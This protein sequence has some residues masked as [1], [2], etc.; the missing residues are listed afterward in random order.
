MTMPMIPAP[1]NWPRLS[2]ALVYRDASAAIDW[3]CRAFGFAVRLKIEG[4]DGRILHSELTYGEAVMM[5]AQ[6]RGDAS[7]DSWKAMLKSPQSL[8]GGNSQSIMLYV[9]DADAHCEQARASG[10]TIVDA[11]S[12][13]DYGAEYWADRSYGAI[14]IEGHIWWIT[15]RLRTGSAPQKP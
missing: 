1:A 5:V 14:D 9:D 11:P 10:A 2:S 13:H 8:S 4:D 7:V 3:L 12:T 6:E 15:Q